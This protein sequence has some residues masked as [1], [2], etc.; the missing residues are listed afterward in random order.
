MEEAAEPAKSE[1]ELLRERNIARNKAVMLA[2]GLIDDDVTLHKAAR[3][4]KQ[5]KPAAAKKRKAAAEPREGS[6]RSKRVRGQTPE[7]AAGADE[8]AVARPEDEDDD[9]VDDSRHEEA[10]AAHEARW[11][12]QQQRATIVGTASYA[13]TL[14][15]VRTMSEAALWTRMKKIEQAKGQHA[16]TKMRLFARVCFLEE[17]FDLADACTEALARLV[18]ALGDPCEDEVVETPAAA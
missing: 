10:R 4:T 3:A 9:D 11:S 1:Y 18:A 7:G 17:Y 15:R 16:V 5:A 13:H 14:M 12:G 2:L 6:R 8:A